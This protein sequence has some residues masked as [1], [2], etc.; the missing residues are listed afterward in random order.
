MEIIRNDESFFTRFGQCYLT[1]CF[2]GIVKAWHMHEYQEDNICAIRGNVK[3]VLSDLREK[4]RTAMEINEFFMGEQK[5]LLIKIPPGVYHGF[6]PLGGETA[7]LLNIPSKPYD[8]E[9]PDEHRLPIDTGKI[10][11]SWPTINR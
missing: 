2:P 9:K 1:T 8:R 11:Y 4:S 10:D 6:T 5:P 7:V 3:L